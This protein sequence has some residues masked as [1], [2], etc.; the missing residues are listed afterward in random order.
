MFLLSQPDQTPM[1]SANHLASPTTE[2]QGMRQ[3]ETSH[4]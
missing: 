2:Q 1:Q 3:F 4:N